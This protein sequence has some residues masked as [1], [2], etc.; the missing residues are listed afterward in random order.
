GMAA[1]SQGVSR[2]LDVE[3]EDRK[4]DRRMSVWNLFFLSMGG[5]IG[6][7][8]LF[9]SLAAAAVAGP[10]AIVSWIIGGCLVLL[11]ALNYAEISGMM[12][13]SG[14]IVRYPH[15]THG[16]YTGFILGWTYLLSAVSV[17]A[18]EAEAVVTYASTY[19]HGIINPANSELTWPAGILFGIGL[20]IVFFIFNFIGIRF[21]SRSNHYITLWKFLIPTLT[22]IL[23]F[24][25]GM[26]T[27]NYASYGGFA[28]LG[29]QPVLGAV[30]TTGIVFSYLGFRQALDF[31][32]E[33]RNPQR[34]VPR[35]TIAS[36]LAGMVLYVLLQA[37]FIGA[38]K[39]G[40]FGV[41]AG[42]WAALKAAG[43]AAKDAPFYVALKAAGPALLG[44]FA[45]VLLIDAFVSPG[46]TGVVYL[47]TSSRTTY[48]LSMVGYLPSPFR[49]IL[50][51]TRIPW[52]ALIASFVVACLF[53]LPLPSW[54][55][56]VG[57]ITSATVLTYI[58]GGIGVPVLRQTAG[59]LHR[60]F[61]LPLA[62]IIAPAGFIGAL[63][64][65]YWS[66]FVTLA[67]VFGAVFVA[68]P[69]FVWFYA[70]QQGWIKP[71]TGWLLGLV[72]LV[73]WIIVQRWGGWVLTAAPLTAVHP[74]FGVYYFTTI[75]LVM[76][77]TGIL[78][79]AC[80][81]VGRKAV[82]STWWLIYFLLAVFGLSYFGSYG[83][84]KVPGL[85]FPSDLLVVIMVGLLSYG[86]AVR[87]GYATP[88]L[89]TIIDTGTAVIGDEPGVPVTPA[90]APT[91]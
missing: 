58:M 20:M 1:I 41:H 13:R 43:S 74:A 3:A 51:R 38:I 7:G 15:L 88:E 10:A 78:W 5:I 68:L 26:H 12:P 82:Q 55:E 80:N 57:V 90:T 4:L 19:I 77:F 47:G 2:Q 18:I 46:G 73:L 33:A 81:P 49:A 64:I 70:P 61:R 66:G 34:D 28:P 89:Q 16:G 76:G 53:F 79:Y 9:A 75:V 17:P 11:V 60:P 54:Y 39:W 37:A 83:P 21:M 31:G 72:F 45:T 69:I 84:L 63:M 50:A 91:T 22:F 85:T 87:S 23:L 48:G 36:V 35:A 6:S 42:D 56:L 30:A 86:W 25:F 65:V 29:W 32:G 40:V 67:L 8:W 14:A 24:A 52:I 59:S 44:G 27:K 71:Q 62:S